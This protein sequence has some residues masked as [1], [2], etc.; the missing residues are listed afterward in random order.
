MGKSD[1]G[2]VLGREVRVD[3]SGNS[4]AAR[5]TEDDQEPEASFEI[6]NGVVDAP[7]TLRAQHVAGN[8]NHEQLVGRLIEDPLDRYAGVRAT[9]DQ[10]IRSL[11]DWSARDQGKSQGERVRGD[12]DRRGT[13][14]PHQFLLNMHDDIAESLVSFLQLADGQLRVHRLSGNDRRERLVT[15]DDVHESCPSQWFRRRRTIL[16]SCSVVAVSGFLRIAEWP[17]PTQ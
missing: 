1:L 15:V 6:L 8:A 13:S 10:S 3:G 17:P 9:Q 12:D 14:I 4:A 2:I 5:M 11:L 16:S 7:Q